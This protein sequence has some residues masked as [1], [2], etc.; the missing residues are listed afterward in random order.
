MLVLKK[1]GPV[2]YAVQK[3]K[4]SLPF[5]THVD[6]LKRCFKPPIVLAERRQE[7]E[8]T[9]KLPNSTYDV[10]CNVN[11]CDLLAAEGHVDDVNNEMTVVEPSHASRP[12]RQIRL[13]V[14]YRTE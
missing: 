5:V 8:T 3:S 6:K 11:D 13:P 9:P 1:L 2:N 4:N 7:T 12:R 14:R 10:S